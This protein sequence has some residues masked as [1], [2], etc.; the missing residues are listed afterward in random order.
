MG[1]IERRKDSK[2]PVKNCG[3]DLVNNDG[4]YECLKCNYGQVERRKEDKGW[5][6]GVDGF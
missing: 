3:G 1:K 5:E 4:R 2:C 6:H